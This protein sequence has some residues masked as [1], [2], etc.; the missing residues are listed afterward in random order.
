MSIDHADFES[1]SRTL[2]RR[3]LSDLLRKLPRDERASTIEEE[4]T[5]LAYTLAEVAETRVAD[6]RAAVDV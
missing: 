6:L 5:S 1:I 3:H 4:A 2:I